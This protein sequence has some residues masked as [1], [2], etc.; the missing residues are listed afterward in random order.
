LK[1]LLYRLDLLKINT[2]YTVTT[3]TMPKGVDLERFAEL[4]VLECMR[5]SMKAVEMDAEYEAWYL[6][7]QRFGV[8]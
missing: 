4:I 2:G 6:I 1:I 3:M 5:V 8:E 7:K